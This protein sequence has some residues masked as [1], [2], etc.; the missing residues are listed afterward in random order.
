MLADVA[1]ELLGANP[2]PQLVAHPLGGGFAGLG[3]VVREE[4]G[5]A[6][7]I[8]RVTSAVFMAAS[9]SAAGGRGSRLVNGGGGAVVGG[10]AGNRG[11]RAVLDGEVHV[12][13]ERQYFVVYLDGVGGGVGQPGV[14]GG[15]GGYASC[16]RR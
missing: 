15:H 11:G 5:P 9:T 6:G 7:V 3:G 8:C 1:G 2:D 16:L 10:G 14:G 13:H 4:A 12:D